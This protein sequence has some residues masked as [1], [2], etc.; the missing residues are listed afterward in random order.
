MS[1]AVNELTKLNLV[2]IKI[3]VPQGSVLGPILFSVF[4]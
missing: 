2:N 3:G 4:Y 1:Y